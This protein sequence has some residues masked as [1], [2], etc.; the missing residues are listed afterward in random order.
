MDSSDFNCERSHCP[1]KN[2]HMTDIPPVPSNTQ[3]HSI[4]RFAKN[5]SS[6]T[7]QHFYHGD[8]FAL[9]VYNRQTLHPPLFPLS[10]DVTAQRLVSLWY[11]QQ[12]NNCKSKADKITCKQMCT[13][14][15]IVLGIPSD[16]RWYIF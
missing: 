5:T 2:Y 9:E 13:A 16:N 10:A 15:F 1:I 4:R 14:S 7:T 3:S 11:P 8:G 6:L 12:S